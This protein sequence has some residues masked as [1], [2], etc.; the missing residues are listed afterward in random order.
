AGTQWT[1]Q[2]VKTS[3]KWTAAQ[4]RVAAPKQQVTDAV[5]TA[6][7]FPPVKQQDLQGP[8]DDAF[9]DSFVFVRPTG[10]ALNE[11]VAGWVKAELERAVPQWRTVFRGDARVVDDSAV[12]A[13]MIPNS[14]LVLWGDPSSN[15]LLARLLP[16]LP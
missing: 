10:K 15:K 9:M 12:T 16:Q 13:E 2:C 4:S 11:A 3:G 1:A 6:A 7:T 5:G 8:I 14:N